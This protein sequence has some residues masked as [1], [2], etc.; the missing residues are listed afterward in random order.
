MLSWKPENGFWAE[1]L[2]ED[3]R[4]GIGT[5][6][7]VPLTAFPLAVAIAGIENDRQFIEKQYR[8]RIL[9]LMQ[10]AQVASCLKANP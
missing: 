2:R 1:R 6:D 3:P 9:D 4:Y 5:R 8:L 10:Q 7:E